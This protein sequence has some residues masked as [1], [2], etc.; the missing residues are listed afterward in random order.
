MKFLLFALL[1]VAIPLRAETAPAGIAA[2]V[3]GEVITKAELDHQVD[4]WF[5]SSDLQGDQLESAR[6]EQRARSLQALIGRKLVLQAFVREGEQLPQG[7]VDRRLDAIVAEEFGGDRNALLTTIKE[8]GLTREQY[9]QEIA[10]NWIV[11]HM[12]QKHREPN[13]LQSLLATA[14]VTI[15]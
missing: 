7:E 1:L 3:N 14:D 2:K 4:S 9:R 15:L 11:N 6:R 10:D 12:R 5:V 13:W 8:R